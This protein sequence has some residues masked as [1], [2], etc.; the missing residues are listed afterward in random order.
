M[1]P[2]LIIIKI[3]GKA[4]SVSSVMGSFKEFIFILDELNH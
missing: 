1:E 3:W 2:L 4:C